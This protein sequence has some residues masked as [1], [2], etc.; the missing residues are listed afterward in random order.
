MVCQC[1]ML[2]SK[3]QTP[4]LEKSDSK[5]SGYDSA[6]SRDSIF[7]DQEPTLDGER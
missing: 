5:D 6:E 4:R 2:Q 3:S 7:V 1:C